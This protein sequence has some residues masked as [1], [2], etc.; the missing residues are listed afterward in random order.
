MFVVSS[1]MR[2]LEMKSI[3]HHIIEGCQSGRKYFAWLIDPDKYTLESLAKKLLIAEK[4]K[5]DFI[6]LG[7]SLLVK[8]DIEDHLKLIKENVR[9]PV[10]LFPGS[11]HP[12]SKLADGILFLSPI[13]GRNPG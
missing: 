4:A 5:V 9:I 10:I 7:G 1:K 2:F 11:T 3:Y 8:N 12:I 6:L 13:S